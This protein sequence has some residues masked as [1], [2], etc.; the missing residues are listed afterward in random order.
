MKVV[1]FGTSDFAVPPLAAI[2]DRISLV[3]TQPDRVSGRGMKASRPS[4]VKRFALKHGLPVETP[5]KSRSPSFVEKLE[6]LK[7]DLFVVASYGQILSR[8]LLDVPKHGCVNLHASLLPKY[9]GAAPIQRAIENGEIYSG[10]TLMQM[11]EGLDTGPII[12][13]ET[14][15]IGPNETAGELH[16]RL[17]D[18]AARLIEAWLPVLARGDYK[19]TRQDDAEASYARKIAKTDAK[20]SFEQSADETYNKIRAFTP[21]PGAFFYDLR[22]TVQITEARPVDAG[23]GAPGQVL[24]VKPELVVACGKG[25]MR[26][27]KLKPEGKREVSGIDYANGKR[28]RPGDSIIE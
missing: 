10:I 1:Y 14:T 23:E 5:E 19:G 17:A 15:S 11:E 9:R 20:V 12:S 27:L 21:Y 13:Y 22:G 16:D 4:P 2:A 24:S 6:A 8:R 28:L 3:I 26:L 7:P 18:L 25:S